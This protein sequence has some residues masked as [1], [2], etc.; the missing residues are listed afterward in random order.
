[1]STGNAQGGLGGES[2][3]GIRDTRMI[4]KAIRERW[5]IPEGKRPAIAQMLCDV[6]ESKDASDRGKIAAAKALIEID[7]L[8]MEQ[9][10]RD[11]AIPEY[12]SHAVSVV[13]IVEDTNWYG[14]NPAQN[15]PPP[16]GDGASGGSPVEPGSV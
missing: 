12:H 3:R 1:M 13:E 5:P 2:T 7:K 4:E 9:E 15:D 16:E 11:L 8:N 10:R 6:A 14:R